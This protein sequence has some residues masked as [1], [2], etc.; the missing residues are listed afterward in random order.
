[1]GLKTMGIWVLV[2]YVRETPPGQA[3]RKAVE[4]AANAPC[5]DVSAG[6]SVAT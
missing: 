4:N 6:G 1:M 5:T 3:S 2:P